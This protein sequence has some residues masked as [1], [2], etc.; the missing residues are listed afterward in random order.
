MNVSGPKAAIGAYVRRLMVDA[1][2]WRKETTTDAG[3]GQTVAW[4]D[5]DR[6]VAVQLVDPSDTEREAAQQ[7]GVELTHTAVM[8]ADADVARGDRL[9]VA[10]QDDPVEL[11]SDPQTATHSAVARAP[12]KQEP[13]D[14]PTS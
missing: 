3:G 11:T 9:V 8:P 1:Q 4:V 13:W 7:A 10:G 12:V 2:V 6:T 5:Q 14:E